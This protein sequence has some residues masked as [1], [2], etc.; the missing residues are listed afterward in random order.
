MSVHGAGGIHCGDFSKLILARARVLKSRP[1][2][3]LLARS[4]SE[5][6]REDK[7]ILVL[8]TEAAFFWKR[9]FQAK[10]PSFYFSITI[11]TLFPS[12]F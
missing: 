2:P 8:L 10:S 6:Q 4:H 1:T 12:Y 9:H 7:I 3:F 5:P 11:S